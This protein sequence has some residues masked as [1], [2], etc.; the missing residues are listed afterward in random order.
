MGFKIAQ[1]ILDHDL[2]G[3]LDSLRRFERKSSQTVAVSFRRGRLKTP[4]SRIS[5]SPPWT[6]RSTILHICGSVKW[7]PVFTKPGKPSPLESAIRE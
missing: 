6:Y 7:T 2:L 1:K 4:L 5:I 3:L